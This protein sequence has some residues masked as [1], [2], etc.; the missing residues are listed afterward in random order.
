M[1]QMTR[2]VVVDLWP[3]YVS[4]EA[5]ADTRALV[6]TFI[7]KD[8]EFGERLRLQDG[9]GLRPSAVVLPPDHERATLL[10]IQKRRARQ[11]MVV[12][13]LALLVSG[14]LTAYYV[15]DVVPR[16]AQTY[17]AAGLPLPAAMHV[18]T[19][20]SAWALRLG[21]PLVLLGAPLAI[22]FRK[23]LRVPTFLESGVALAVITGIAVVVAQLGWLSLLNEASIALKGA[24]E[25]FGARR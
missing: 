23:R 3:L 4:G 20:A 25:A 9:A 21:L 24:Y 10:R 7:E 1:N 18:A 11:A 8:R 5:S 16:W 6:E 2:D 14:G 12:N 22:A 15:W 13:A 17:A 19:N